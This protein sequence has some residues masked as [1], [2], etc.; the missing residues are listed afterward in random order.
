MDWTTTRRLRPGLPPRASTEALPR[1]PRVVGVP[2]RARRP[3]AGGRPA[4]PFALH[5]AV[6]T[7]DAAWATATSSS[8]DGPIAAVQQRRPPGVRGPR[9]R[10]GDPARAD[11]PARAPG[12][13]RLRRLGAARRSSPTA[14]RG[15]PATS[16]TSSSATRRTSCS[17]GCRRRPSC[18]TP[19]SAPWSAASPPSRAPAPAAPQPATRAAGAQR[20]PV[21][22]RAAP[23]PRHDRPAVG[24]RRGTS[25]PPRRRSSPTSPPATSTPSTCTCPKACAATSAARREFQRFLDLG[26]ATSGDHPHPRQRPDRRPDLHTVAD[27]GCR[28][29]W[30]PQSNLRLYGETTLAAEALARGHAGRARAPTGCRPARPACSPR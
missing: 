17:P 14:T 5:G 28:L 26:A 11:R 18:A 23:G 10:R 22:L 21:D 25:P 12:V 6:I 19:R 2:G 9:D 15:G 16:T 30:S 20:R 1:L 13:Q 27:A 3:A 7:P 24:G 29:V 8:T 4:A